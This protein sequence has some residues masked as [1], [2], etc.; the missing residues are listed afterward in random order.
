MRYGH[1]NFRSLH[2]LSSKNLEYYLPKLNANI[3]SCEASLRGE[4]SRLSFTIDM[5]QREN[6]TLKVVHSNIC[7]PFEVS[8]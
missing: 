8:S 2:E 5:S 3:L 4:H 1:L 7:G 6:N